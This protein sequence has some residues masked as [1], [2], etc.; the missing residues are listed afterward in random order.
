[1]SGN[2]SY[3]KSFFTKEGT[4]HVASGR[5]GNVIGGGDW[6]K[7]RIIP[8]IIRALEKGQSIAVRNP[9]A[10]RPWQHVLEPLSGYL[11]TGQYLFENKKI[12]GEA[13]NFG[14]S[15]E[16]IRTVLELSSELEKR[17]FG[18]NKS[19]IQITDN[20]PFEEAKLL[21]L[22]CDKNKSMS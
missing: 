18:S 20:I 19:S 3:I 10:I 12:N 11:T 14:P 5:A 16:Q 22:N 7:D 4:T 9:N 2:G 6:N 1:M 15:S 13:F 17:W 8:D 21:K